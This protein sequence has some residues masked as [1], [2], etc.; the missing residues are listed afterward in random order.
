MRYSI[1]SRCVISLGLTHFSSIRKRKSYNYTTGADGKVE[2]ILTSGNRSSKSGKETTTF[3]L[4]LFPDNPAN[5]PKDSISQVW[6]TNGAG[7][8][9]PTLFEIG[10]PATIFYSMAYG[11]GNISGHSVTFRTTSIAGL[12]WIENIGEDWDDDAEADGYYD[13]TEY[14]EGEAGF[15]DWSSLVTWEQKP[16]VEGT[17]SA[18]MTVKDDAEGNFF[19]DEVGFGFKDASVM[20]QDTGDNDEDDEE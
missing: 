1:Y 14:S 13:D 8:G 18:E 15:E 7:W 16:E 17:Y 12:E 4:N 2:G 10:V 9:L 20:R 6:N 11:R 5:N 19:V 3:Q